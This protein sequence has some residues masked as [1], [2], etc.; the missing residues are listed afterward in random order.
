METG[1]TRAP[2]ERP[3]GDTWSKARRAQLQREPLCRHC[4]AAGRVTLALEVDHV[5]PLAA[6]GAPLDP[7]NLQSLCIPCHQA[8]TLRDMKCMRHGKP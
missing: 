8:K 3:R 5:V 1:R 2:V 7:N 6:G 4:T